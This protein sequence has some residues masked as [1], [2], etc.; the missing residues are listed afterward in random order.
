MQTEHFHVI[1]HTFSPRIPIPTPLYLALATS[2]F[3]QADT[4]S[5][6]L[7]RSRCTNHLSLHAAPHP[8]HS[9]YLN[10]CTNSHCTFYILQRHST[11][12]LTIIHSIQAMQ[13][14]SLQRPCFSPICTHTLHSSSVYIFPFMWYDVHHGLPGYLRH[15]LLWLLLTPSH[16]FPPQVCR[17]NSKTWEHIPTSHWAP[18][19]PLS[20][21]LIGAFLHLLR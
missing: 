20:A 18:S 10:D 12:P 5:S 9:V 17:P 11:H 6:T 15:I 3:L 7:L 2:T 8:P 14:L 16:L 13:I 19:Q 21:K 1:I 4:Q